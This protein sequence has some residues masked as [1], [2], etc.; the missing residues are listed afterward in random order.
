M[1][2]SGLLYLTL[3]T[4]RRNIS[5]ACSHLNASECDKKTDIGVYSTRMYI[6][7]IMHT[8]ARNN[9]NNNKNTKD[10]ACGLLNYNG[11]CKA[12]EEDNDQKATE[13]KTRKKECGQ[14]VSDTARE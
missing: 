10:N 8:Y 13:N 6:S 14:Q 5:Q 1:K 3:P 4:Q 12:P 9:N 2:L 7:Y 11:H